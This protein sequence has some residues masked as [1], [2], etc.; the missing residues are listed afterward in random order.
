MKRHPAIHAV[1]SIGLFA[2]AS[3]AA[4][5]PPF[6][7]PAY[8]GHGDGIA[9]IAVADVPADHGYSA[10]AVVQADGGLVVAG[11]AG[12]S[13]TTQLVLA[14]FDAQG[15]PDTAFGPQHDGFYRSGFNGDD[16]F[17]DIAQTGDGKLVYAGA[18]LKADAMIVGRLL[19]DG[20]PDTDFFG[21][22]GQRVIT[23]SML[24]T[25]AIAGYL[26]TVLPLPDDK[27]LVLGFVETPPSPHQSYSC[28][29]RLLADGSTDV[30]FG[31]GGR[32]CVAPPTTGSE[33]S[34]ARSGRVLADG[35]ILLAGASWHS[36][37]SEYDMSVARL[38]AD[39]ALDTSFGP[40]H[41]GWAIVAFDQGGG[42]NDKAIAITVDGQGRILLAGYFDGASGNNDIGIVRLLPDGQLDT[43]F[44]SQ[45]RVQIALDLGGSNTDRAHSI[46]VL[47]NGDIVGGGVAHT[48]DSSV[49][50]A[51]FL[52]PDGTLDLRYGNIVFLSDPGA[53]ETAKVEST[54]Q[55]LAGDYLTLVGKALSTSGHLDFAAT[56]AVMPL[57]ADGFENPDVTRAATTKRAP[58]SRREGNGP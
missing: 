36:G 19:A 38:G 1:A 26:T 34:Q 6:P 50:I 29:L 11:V 3:I 13:T 5:P 32:T 2:I 47:P 28:A 39:G 52:K 56:R 27:I 53:P 35:R 8:G 58:A 7:D 22:N 57:F 37:N 9:R 44:G 4:A 18:G 42:W 16:T 54:Q 33:V 43:S 12:T 17:L 14:R 41:D 20:R 31:S 21:S 51:I 48:I 55:I 30:G 46:A 15:L 24:M 40:E 49:S 45:G 10:H 25:G 23:P